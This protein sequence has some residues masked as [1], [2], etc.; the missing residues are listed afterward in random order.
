MTG[1]LITALR[2][3]SL[4]KSVILHKGCEP[5]P[6]QAKPPISLLQPSE[7]G[8]ALFSHVSTL[9]PLWGILL[10][11]LLYFIYREKSR[12]VCL[13]ALQGI[14]F[15]VIL[16]CAI[17]AKGVIDL[18]A[19]LVHPLTDSDAFEQ[20]VE[21][22]TTYGLGGLYVLFAVCCLIGAWHALRGRILA[23]PLVGKRVGRA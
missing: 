17:G 16:L 4:L 15:S 1:P 12:S 3:V 23:Y 5:M 10:N 21:R 22:I 11:A 19:G 20:N 14:H 13:Q 2:S 18:F 9:I 6:P 8:V 7:R